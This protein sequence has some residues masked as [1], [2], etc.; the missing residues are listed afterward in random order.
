M[1]GIFEVVDTFL[2]SF[3]RVTDPLLQIVLET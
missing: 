1:K 3:G 2:E